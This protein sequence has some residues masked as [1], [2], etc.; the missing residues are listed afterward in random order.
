MVFLNEWLPNPVGADTAG[1]FLEPYNGGAATVSLDGWSIKTENGKSFSLGGRT[2]P[3][4]GYLVLKHDAT[5]LTLRNTDGRLSLYAP[6]GAFC[7]GAS[8]ARRAE[9]NGGHHRGGVLT[10]VQRC[11]EPA[12]H[13]R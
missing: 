3:P 11:V 4:Q 13:F 9:Q 8:D 10:T 5:K 7:L 6:G 2:I 12:V 1:E